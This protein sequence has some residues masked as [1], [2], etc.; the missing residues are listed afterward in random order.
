MD[1]RRRVEL[2]ATAYADELSIRSLAEIG[3]ITADQ[4]VR[5]IGGQMTALLLTAFP[6]PGIAVRRTRDIDAGITAEL[7][8]SGVIHQRLLDHGYAATSGNSYTRPL[9][10][11][12]VAGGPVPELAVDLLIPSLD[13]RFRSQEHGGRAF[14]A[15]PGLA[16]ALA[17]DPIVIDVGG[18]MLNGARLEFS[19]PVPTVELALV[20]KALAYGSRLQARDAE[21]IYRLLEIINLY[22]AGE[23][24][25]R[26]LHE[27]P[28]RAS[29]RDAAVHLHEL[30]RRSRRRSDLD[31]P[32]A[33][34]ATLIAA[35]VGRVG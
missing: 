23:I 21:D 4:N 25:G 19:V 8:G 35:L 31:V 28:L 18:R 6:V 15:A 29:R 34:L 27:T 9:P 14:D 11:L 24:G 3:T 12:A 1:I 10:D 2:V 5:I 20:I 30:A 26:R 22:P 33:R 17:A 16:P 32:A 7:A 13:G